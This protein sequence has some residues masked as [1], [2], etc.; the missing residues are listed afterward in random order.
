M[1][2]TLPQLL[3]RVAAVPRRRQMAMQVLRIS[4]D[5]L[6]CLLISSRSVDDMRNTNPFLSEAA[7]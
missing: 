4:A 3:A 1:H 6:R 7:C 2:R 5:F